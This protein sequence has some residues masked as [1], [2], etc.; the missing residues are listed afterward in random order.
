MFLVHSNNEYILLKFLWQ[1]ILS[2]FEQY[3]SRKSANRYNI[4]ADWLNSVIG[5]TVNNVIFTICFCFFKLM[6]SP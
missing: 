6:N 2:I 3:E 5:I 1:A 4:V